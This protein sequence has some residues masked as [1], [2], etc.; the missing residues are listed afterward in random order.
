LKKKA[1]PSGVRLF[2]NADNP[3]FAHRACLGTG[4]AA[5]DDPVNPG[6]IERFPK[7]V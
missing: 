2:L 7:P 3:L 6:Q 5:D 4:L 1:T